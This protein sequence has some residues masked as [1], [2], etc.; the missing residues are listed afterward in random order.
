[1]KGKA[2]SNTPV[3]ARPNGGPPCPSSGFAYHPSG[4]PGGLRRPRVTSNVG[5]HKDLATHPSR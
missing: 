2:P 5:L 1:M 4:W 3:E